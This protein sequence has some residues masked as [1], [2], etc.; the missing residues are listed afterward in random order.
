MRRGET[1]CPCLEMGNDT[2]EHEPHWI[3]TNDPLLKREM[4]FLGTKS[5]ISCLYGPDLP[6]R[7]GRR[8]MPFLQVR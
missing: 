4:L 1:L 6:A 3:R 7:F 8:E 5:L 2:N